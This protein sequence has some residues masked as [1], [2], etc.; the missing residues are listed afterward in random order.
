LHGVPITVKECFHLAGTAATLGLGSR[1]TVL[2]ETDGLLVARLKQAGAII[3]GKTNVPQ[4]MMWHEADNPVYGRTNNPW[5]LSR[6]CGGS[7]GG[8]AAIIA[9]RGSPLGLAN[10]L[11]GSIRIPAHFCGVHG[12]KPTTRR[13][14]RGSA[15]ANFRGLLAVQSQAGVIARTVA[16]LELGLNVLCGDATAEHE[17]SAENPPVPLRA[18]RDLSC[19]GMR[20]GV[21]D[22]DG[23]F[24]ASNA[25]KRLVSEAAD[26][27][28]NCGVEV[29]KVTP[30]FAVE[31]ME[32][33]LS[34]VAADGGADARRLA[35]GSRLDWRLSRILLL[36]RLPGWLRTLIN[37]GFRAAG[38][39][40]MARLVAAAAP[41]SADR[42]WQL[43]FQAAERTRDFLRWMQEQRISA[44]LCPPH[45]LPAIPHELAIDLIA[46]SSYAFLP[47][48]LGFPAG[49]VALSRVRANEDRGRTASMDRAVQR[50][51]ET[52]QGSVGLPLSLQVVAAP[53]REDVAFAVMQR[54]ET[55]F[56][57]R[58]D[59]P[60]REVVPMERNPDASPA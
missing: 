43:A 22:D 60:L 14:P 15:V 55:A 25:L 47:N 8:E 29:V 51:Y 26:V 6:T 20:I 41:L 52:D 50:A 37:W 39:T 18:S 46:A 27:L 57:E 16:D 48:L 59:Y 10:D 31:L 42:E 34:L 24:P 30:P 17:L 21:W 49:T 54:L 11:G 58:D 56:A 19:P 1:A 2:S 33:Y 12:F 44:F 7:S 28:T 3:L 36:E 13:L 5:D 35:T 40:T 4:L 9:A 23:F 45:A 32:L 53:W 38:Q